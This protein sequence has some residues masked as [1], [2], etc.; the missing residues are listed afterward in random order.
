LPLAR[1]SEICGNLPAQNLQPSKETE[2]H[3]EK[4]P[5]FHRVRPAAPMSPDER[6]NSSFTALPKEPPGEEIEYGEM[7]EREARE[8]GYINDS[9]RAVEITRK[10]IKGSPTNAFTDIGAGRSGVVKHK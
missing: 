7:T 5:E 8:S 1:S 2:V 3:V 9:G 10:D 6:Y 4:Y